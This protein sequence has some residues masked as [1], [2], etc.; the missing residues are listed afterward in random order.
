MFYKRER[1]LWI[2]NQKFYTYSFLPIFST[3]LLNIMNM[4]TYIKNCMQRYIK[5]Y[6]KKFIQYLHLQ[7]TE[8]I[9]FENTLQYIL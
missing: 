4:I 5:N 3:F 7:I 9:S 8:P 2:I 1:L 6:M